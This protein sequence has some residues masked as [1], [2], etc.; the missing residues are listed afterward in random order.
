MRNF[1]LMPLIFIILSLK[2]VATEFDCKQINAAQE[3][4]DDFERISNWK[5]FYRPTEVSPEIL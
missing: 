2:V 3:I 1:Y 4:T 5:E